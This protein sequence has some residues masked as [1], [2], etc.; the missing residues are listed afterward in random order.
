[1]LWYNVCIMIKKVEEKMKA[2]ELRKKGLSYGEIKKLV[3][4]SKSS[5]SLWLRDINLTEEQQK[6]ISDIS[7]RNQKI[8][9]KKSRQKRISKTKEIHRKAKAEVDAINVCSNSKF[10]LGVMLYWCEGYK[11]SWERTSAMISL[12]N[13]D[14]KI[15]SFFQDW[16]LDSFDLKSEDLTYRLAIHETADLQDALD[17]WRK[18]LRI[19]K[20]RDIKVFIKKHKPLTNRKNKNNN[21]HGLFVIRVKKSTD[22]NRKIWGWIKAMG[23]EIS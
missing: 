9:A 14:P 10:L 8:A 6:R 5:L 16:L 18:K 1:M 17:Y 19:S 22:L 4:V 11:Q 20:S 23:S 15:M 2:R 3:N 13:F 21:Y 12:G 7:R